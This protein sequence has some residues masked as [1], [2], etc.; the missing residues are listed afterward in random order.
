[1][2]VHHDRGAVLILVLW[3]AVILSSIA[4]GSAYIARLDMRSAY[5]PVHEMQAVYGAVAGVE[6]SIAELYYDTHTYTCLNQQWKK[7]PEWYNL[8][9]GVG[10]VAVSIEDEESKVNINTASDAVLG[11]LLSS[12]RMQCATVMRDSLLDWKDTDTTTRQCG[13]EDSYYT[14]QAVYRHCKNGML[15]CSEEL[16]MI[17]GFEDATTIKPLLPC[18]TVYGSGKIN[19][20]T[21][22]FEVLSSLPGID[23]KTARTIVAYRSGND[24]IDGTSDD[25]IFETTDAVQPV[26]GKKIFA[27]IANYIT[28]KSLFFNVRSVAKAGTRTKIVDAM[29]ERVGRD[30][31]I[32]YWRELT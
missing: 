23:Y 20:N 6:N 2:S 29:L 22:S 24:Y 27:Q 19:I 10:T 1:M 32:K 28:V 26:V 18:V 30:V 12:L 9:I 31:K 16:S 14:Q 15:D 11:Q 4:L 5:A 13:A 3:I 21:A 8:Q 17:Q 25:R 7:N